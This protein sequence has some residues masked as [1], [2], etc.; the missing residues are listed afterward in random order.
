MPH[1]VLDG[2][3]NTYW[4]TDDDVTTPELILDFGRER[5]F[6]V[7]KLREYLPLGQRVE[8]FALDQWQDGQ[9]T[10]FAAATSIGSCRLVRTR[11]VSTSKLRLRIAQ[12]PVCPAIAEVSLFEESK[13]R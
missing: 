3:R 9:W 1:N 7:V 8:H 10:E 4:T 5:T 6:N 12:S 11:Q 13:S 2:D